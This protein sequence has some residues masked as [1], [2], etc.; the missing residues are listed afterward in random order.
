MKELAE[1]YI[2]Y[3]AALILWIA[4][5]LIS[6]LLFFEILFYR[7]FYALAGGW[8]EDT[9]DQWQKARFMAGPSNFIVRWKYNVDSYFAKRTPLHNKF[10]IC[11]YEVVF[12]E[13]DELA[14]IIKLREL[15]ERRKLQSV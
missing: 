9:L 5:W 1:G 14:E 15:E 10:P 7:P 13:R 8:D 4:F 2:G 12:K 11:D 3:E 6:Y